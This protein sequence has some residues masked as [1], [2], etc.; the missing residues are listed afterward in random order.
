MT[1]AVLVCCRGGG[2]L[3]VDAGGGGVDGVE[4]GADIG[5]VARRAFVDA[6]G[7]RVVVAADQ[8]DEADVTRWN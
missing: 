3:D 2:L 8:V 1:R 4:V 7:R 5:A 6:G